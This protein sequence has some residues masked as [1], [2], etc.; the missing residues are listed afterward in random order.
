[1][2]AISLLLHYRMAND[3]MMKLIRRRRQRAWC[4]LGLDGELG[5]HC[6]GLVWFRLVVP[7]A[8]VVTK[9]C[10]IWLSRWYWN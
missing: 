10:D 1:M 9:G 3:I 4:F 8:A 2:V 6:Y 5:I 7:V